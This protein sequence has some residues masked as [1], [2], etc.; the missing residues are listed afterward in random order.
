VRDHV[1]KRIDA[2]WQ[3]GGYMG[4]HL[5]ASPVEHVEGVWA[6]SSMHNPRALTVQCDASAPAV[7]PHWRVVRRWGPSGEFVETER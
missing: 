1:W 2:G 6:Y 3:V 4:A 5:S 7:K